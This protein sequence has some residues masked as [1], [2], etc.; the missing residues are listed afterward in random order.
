MK[1]AIAQAFSE[2]GARR[3]ALS[4]QARG[5]AKA[6]LDAATHKGLLLIT[7]SCNGAGVHVELMQE[8]V[9]TLEV[10]SVIN[11]ILDS[12]LEFEEPEIR[13]Q[14]ELPIFEFRKSIEDAL[15]FSS[16]SVPQ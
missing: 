6:I 4:N 1:D 5:R 11:T 13:A 14:I 15:G 3:P 8:N 2:A 9:S 7:T 10:F 16:E 12:V